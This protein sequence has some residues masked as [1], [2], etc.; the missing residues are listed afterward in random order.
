M[1]YGLSEFG[2]GILFTILSLTSVFGCHNENIL[3]TEWAL[4]SMT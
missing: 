4:F 2:K 3:H 1:T